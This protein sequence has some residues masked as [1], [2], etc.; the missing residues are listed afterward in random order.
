MDLQFNR[1]ICYG[2]ASNFVYF[3]PKKKH[4][5]FYIKLPE[6]DETNTAL[7]G[8]KLEYDYYRRERAYRIKIT[9]IKDFHDNRTMFRELGQAAMEHRK[10]VVE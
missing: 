7:D 5:Y 2:V 8:G 10:T 4:V 6:S 3:R 9:N 1:A